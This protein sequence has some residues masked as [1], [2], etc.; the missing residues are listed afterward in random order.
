MHNLPLKSRTRE[1][2]HLIGSTIGEVLDV[3]GAETD[4]PWDRC[5]RVRVKVDVTKKLVRGKK[6]TLKEGK[7]GGCNLNMRGCQTF[8]IIVASLL[9]I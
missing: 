5:L 7:E 8:A 1:V 3:D 9:M 2:G 4:E 6:V